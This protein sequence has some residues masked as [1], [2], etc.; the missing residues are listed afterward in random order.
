MRRKTLMAILG[1]LGAILAF[2]QNQF[3]LSIDSTAFI[4]GLSVV[5]LYVFFE[6]KADF[7]RIKAQAKKFADPKFW[8]G[9]ISVILTALNEAFNW[10]LPLNIIIPA[11]AFLMSIL[12]GIDINKLK[13]EYG[14]K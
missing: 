5:L 10:N 3:G 6:A 9:L 7:L 14:K 12:F 8:L 2:F 4:G 11:L 1:I 13:L